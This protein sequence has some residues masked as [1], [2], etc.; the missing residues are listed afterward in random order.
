MISH[1]SPLLRRRGVALLMT[2]AFL[3]LITIA[4][5]GLTVSIRLERAASDSHRDRFVAETL[6]RDA[7]ADACAKLGLHAGSTNNWVSQPGRIVGAASGGTQIDTN[8]AVFLYSTPDGS[9]P[10][11]G[12]TNGEAIN[13]REWLASNDSFALTGTQTNSPDPMRVSWIYCRRDGSLSFSD[14]P[15]YD[16]SNPIVGRFAYW[17]DDD[18]S[19]I[20]LNTAADR[21]PAGVPG[22]PANVELA[23]LTGF[24]TNVV[25]SLVAA[26]QQDPFRT[27]G[28]AKRTAGGFIADL[29]ATNRFAVSAYNFDPC[30]E[31]LV[32]TTQTNL[33]ADK[34]FLDILK[35]ANTDPGTR[36]NLDG[37]GLTGAVKAVHDRLARTSWP[38]LGG[39]A[40]FP[41]KYG[42]DQ[43]WQ[44]AARIVDFVRCAESTNSI[45]EPVRYKVNGATVKNDISDS[46]VSGTDGEFVSPGRTPLI[47]EMGISYDTDDRSDAYGFP[48]WRVRYYV[49]LYLPTA[50]GVDQIDLVAPEP[51]KRLYIYLAPTTGPWGATPSPG[52]L[53]PMQF[54]NIWR[55]PSDPKG[56]VG[57]R[58]WAGNTFH[59]IEAADVVTL[60]G[61]GNPVR[62]NTTGGT[63]LLTAGHYLTIEKDFWVKVADTKSGVDI[64]TTANFK[65]GNKVFFRAGLAIG[66]DAGRGSNSGSALLPRIAMT[67]LVGATGSNRLWLT[68][69]PPGNVLPNL[70]AG[71]GARSLQCDDPRAGTVPGDWKEASPTFCLPNTVNT[72]GSTPLAVVPPQDTDT[73]GQV[74]D[75]SLGLPAPKGSAANPSGVLGSIAHL[76]MV[77]TGLANWVANTSIPWR[78][79]RFQPTK[80]QT[81][82]DLPDWAVC[83][84]FTVPF[85]AYAPSDQL[86]PYFAPNGSGAGGRVNINAEIH[87]FAMERIEPLKAIFLNVPTDAANSTSRMN[88]NDAEEIAKNV[89]AFSSANNG[90]LYG[91]TNLYESAGEIFEI[92]GVSDGGEASEEVARQIANLIT[93]RSGVF[94][95]AAVGQSV[96]QTSS[97]SIHVN[98]E[99]RMH[100]T[101]ERIEESGTVRFRPVLVKTPQ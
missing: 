88:E 74:S 3:V 83:D 93:V 24:A 17:V 59:R 5:V 99:Q 94:T 64:D 53:V 27:V 22:T 50:Y 11:A 18:C 65:P 56:P 8:A 82:T 44:I 37:A 43:T 61:A 92:K 84:L 80:G 15:A 21:S 47:T 57:A 19:R 73:A 71:S 49:E 7:I 1:R 46:S 13:S 2:L 55:N 34:A 23:A 16:A 86:K 42:S 72:V 36:Q 75:A 33:S 76:G 58:E 32:L 39:A 12:T 29:V 96:T 45:V 97:G 63:T 10:A 89:A 14:P 4:V 79:L 78:T 40:S 30:I 60:N 41:A 6:A 81:A 101:V 69:G 9:H 31:D 98:A 68:L 48:Y 26:R 35:T 70:L 91:Q 87:P 95:I 66:A 85:A 90:V 52:Y 25:A 62:G 77:P 100:A 28:D 51:G 54:G 38:M 20:N 67:P